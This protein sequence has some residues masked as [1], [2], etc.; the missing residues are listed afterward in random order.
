MN[1]LELL[2]R[3]ALI[4]AHR[5]ARAL[6]PENT[7]SSLKKSVGC[8]DFI[9]VDVQFSADAIAII[10]HDDTLSRTTNVEEIEKFKSRAPY[11]VCDF[12][13]AELLELDYGSWF[14]KS[15]PFHQIAEGKVNT[16]ELQNKS[17][18]LLSLRDALK[19][20]KENTLF[21]NIEIKGAHENLSDADVVNIIAQEIESWHVENLVLVSSFL[22]Q[23]LPLCKVQLPSVATAVLI[24]KRDPHADTKELI[25]Y[26]KILKVD[27][28]HL[29][30]ALVSKELVLELQQAGFFVNVYTVNSPLR[31]KELFS[32]GVNGIFTDFV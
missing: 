31:Q 4:G 13:H 18:P 21:I 1:F 28:C 7:L 23:Y 10:M 6:R 27:G 14:V 5:G 24:Q 3:K 32:M 20:V 17:E 26:L 22:H 8:S 16:K 15:D 25:A 11:R 2:E 9:E 19:F 30:D 12:T 29:H